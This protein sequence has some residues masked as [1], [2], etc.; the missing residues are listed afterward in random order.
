MVNQYLNVDTLVVIGFLLVNLTLGLFFSR[1]IKNLTEYTIGNRNFS[2]ATIAATIVATWIDGSSFSLNI[3]ETYNKGL[4]YVIPGIADGLSFFIISYFLAPRMAE[5]LGK[6]SMAEAMGSLYGQQVRII[7]AISGIIMAIAH[8]A[9]DFFILTTLLNNILGIPGIYAVALSSCIVITYSTFG[10][11]KAVTFT[12]MIQFFTFGVVIPMTAFFI[13]NS[14]DNTN[15]VFQAL[16]QS[17]LFNYHEFFNYHH[18]NFFTT[19]FLFL[20]FLIPDLDPAIFQRI[21]MAKNTIQVSKSFYIAGMV[22]IFCIY[23]VFYLIGILLLTGNHQDLDSSNLISYI[24]DN[25]I[26]IG[27]KGFFVI[28]IMSM[29]MSTADSYINSAAVLFAHDIC[30]SLG[31]KLIEQKELLL[32]RISALLIG[33]TALIFSLFSKNLLGFILFTY[34][35]YMPIVTV[36]LLLAIFG[37]RSSKKAVLIG[38]GAG[39]ITIIYLIFTDMENII[40]PGMVANLV[41]F[42]GSH[43]LLGEKGGWIGIRDE[44]PLNALRAERKRKRE[45]LIYSL[46]NFSFINFCK[47]NTPK[48]EKIYVYFGLFCIIL[49]FSSAYTLPKAVHDTHASLLHSIYYSILILSTISITYPFWLEKF[50]NTFVISLIWNIAI[51]HNLVFTSSL[52]ILLS[53]LNHI[54][55]TIFVISL[56]T[57]AILIRWQAALLIISVGIFCSTYLYKRYMGIE[58]LL[59]SVNGMELKMYSLLLVAS[60]LIAFL[61]PKQDLQAFT[62]EKVEHLGQQVS[63]LDEEIKKLVDL[64]NEFL[65][66]IEHEVHAP[67]TGITS[68]GQNLLEGYD[69]LSEPQRR[70][71]AKLI[72]NSSEKLTSFINNILDLAKISSLNYS[73]EL[74]DLNLSKLSYERL[75]ICKR[76]YLNNKD[77]EF[78][79]DLEPNVIL[80]CDEHYIKQTLDNLIINAINYTHNGKIIIRLKQNGPGI[81]FSIEDEGIGIPAKELFDIFGAFTVSSKTRTPSGGRGVGLALCKKT[82]EVHGGKIWAES[83]GEK[84]AIFKFTLPTSDTNKTVT[85]SNI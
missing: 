7:S 35:F 27:F 9:I 37:F 68:L 40:M 3:F 18:P 79:T 60:T 51:L 15:L 49:A 52:L 11:I 47:N 5:F 36:P 34:S 20:F 54:Q 14:L 78:F 38:M 64:K 28:G 66:N 33:I 72:A 73:L 81:E 16:N 84:G 24:L 45:I 62:E 61:K 25:Y 13:W 67:M 1:K 48:E 22:I 30:K 58:N 21:T 85:R 10:G 80:K 53:N 65:R 43:Y 42:M 17:S 77:L 70:K 50:K 76:L 82:I 69:S 41:F 2:T 56:L 63:N 23:G 4:Y 29:I 6:L 83:N 44:S 26:S 59:E 32:V 55:L 39:F 19:I 8:I 31:I 12:D 71:A 46:Q 57:T 74:K 75:E